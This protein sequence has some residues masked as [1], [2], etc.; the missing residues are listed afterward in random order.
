M[1]KHLLTGMLFFSVHAAFS[2]DGASHRYAIVLHNG[3]ENPVEAAR[4]IKQ[5]SGAKIVEYDQTD[6]TFQIETERDLD[7]NV[8]AGKLQ[9]NYFPLKSLVRI[10]KEFPKF[11]DTGNPEMDADSYEQRKKLWIS[12]H[13][14]EYRKMTNK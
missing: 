3:H 2:Q 9:K 11:I 4:L 14:D 5:F 12:A 10:E 8:F 6:S 7:K 13:P 1:F